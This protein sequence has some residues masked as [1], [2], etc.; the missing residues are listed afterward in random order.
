MKY[1]LIS[2]IHSNLPALEAVLADIERR[3]DV[4]ATYHL[5]DLVGYAPWPNETV[6]ALEEWRIPGI[7]GNY[8][9]TVATDYKHC[10]C[11]AD[12]PH[13]EE[14]AHLGY[15][16]TRAHVTRETKRAL[17]ELPFRMDLRPTGGHKSRPQVILVHGTPTLNTLYWTEDRPDSFCVKMARAA[18]AKEGDLIA[19][20]HTH[21][22]WHREVEGIHFLNTGSVGKPKDGDRRAGYVLVEAEEEVKAVEF[23]RVEY[24]VERAAEGILHSTLP[25]DFADQLRAG[26]NPQPVEATQR[27][28]R[29]GWSGDGGD[30]GTLRM[31]AEL[32]E[33]TYGRG[34]LEGA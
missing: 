12:T 6:A 31:P 9:S 4:G 17:G 18:A 13:Q 11:K 7:A 2:D 26:G 14:L 19:F 10:G 16:W 20:G 28:E 23:V 24:D 27:I 25:D 15:E 3:E 21:K 5:G 30:E 29:K 33:K 32:G 1:A 8:D 22:P 34:V